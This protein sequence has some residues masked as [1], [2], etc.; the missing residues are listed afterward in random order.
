MDLPTPRIYWRMAL[1]VGAALAAFVALAAGSVLLVASQE[2]ESYVETRQSS[3]GREAADVLTAGGRAA[4]EGWLHSA[5]LPAD[6]TVFVLDEHSR[7]ILGR[8][9]PSYLEE[10]V[11]SSVVAARELP[12]ANYRPVHLAP[13][14][15]A[16]DGTVYAFLVLPNRISLWGSPATALGLVMTALLVVATVAWLIARAF[17]RPVGELQRAVR[18]LASGRLEARLPPG[19][20]ARRDELGALGADFNSMADQIASLIASRQQ[21]MAELSHELRSPLARLQAALALAAHRERF[22]AAERERVEQEL[23]RLDE[24]IGDLLRFSRLGNAAEIRRRLLRVGPLLEELVQIEGIEA[25][26]RGCVLRLEA[27]PGLAIVGDPD[28]LRSGLE[29][30]VR[31]A[32][33]YS[34]AGA[35]VEM[36]AR[37][38]GADVVIAVADRGPGVPDAY[39][40]RIFEPYFRVPA[41]P[42][43]EPTPG[44]GLGLAIA[45][46]VFEAHG[47]GIAAT[48]RAGGG[49]QVTMRIPT[50][51][52]A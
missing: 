34:P 27:A 20:T 14:L 41:G 35:T 31:N 51:E 49:L 52:F 7:D 8:P 3:L 29:N 12:G 28:L 47:G 5:D 19:I 23:R 26:A 45:R 37:R 43:Q 50:A 36:S 13:Q 10:F 11:R 18:E 21:L 38:A 24:V 39:L 42:G 16:P 22:G 30:V 15:I 4:L 17:G 2:L 32:I 9:L 1:Y 44:T 40:Q 6:V 48:A 46:R 25:S 33:R